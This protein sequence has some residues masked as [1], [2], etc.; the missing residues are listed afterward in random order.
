M[1][2]KEELK[3][4]IYEKVEVI[5]E[6]GRERFIIDLDNL[7]EILDKVFEEPLIEGSFNNLVN[8]TIIIR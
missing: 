5:D 1:I 8:T 4:L 2:T 3:D 6:Q 7:S